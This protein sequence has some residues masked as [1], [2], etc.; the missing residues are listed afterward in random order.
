MKLRWMIKHSPPR[1]YIAEAKTF[2]DSYNPI[3]I[4]LGLIAA[5][6]SEMQMSQMRIVP[7]RRGDDTREATFAIKRSVRALL[8]TVGQYTHP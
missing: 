3:G 4:A 7:K 5:G 2:S 6:G 1:I 8:Q